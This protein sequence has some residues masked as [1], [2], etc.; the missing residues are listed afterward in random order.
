MKRDTYT[1]LP[2]SAVPRN[3][4]QTLESFTIESVYNH[5]LNVLFKVY[6]QMNTK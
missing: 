6:V 5:R 3:S 1:D 2:L 4:V